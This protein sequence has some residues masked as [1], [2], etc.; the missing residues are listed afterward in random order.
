[1][2]GI[3]ASD[4]A[5]GAGAVGLRTT[6]WGT[7]G[8]IVTATVGTELLFVVSGVLKAK[9]A[10]KITSVNKTIPA[11]PIS[12]NFDRLGLEPWAGELRPGSCRSTD[13]GSLF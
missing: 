11:A 8:V 12:M 6:G 13:M 1:L 5:T 10:A 4:V 7:V 9:K 2:T 3:G